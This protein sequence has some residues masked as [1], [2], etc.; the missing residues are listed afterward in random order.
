MKK[1]ILILVSSSALV[2]CNEYQHPESYSKIEYIT[3]TLNDS[4]KLVL[5]NEHYYIYQYGEYRNNMTIQHR[6]KIQ[7]STIIQDTTFIY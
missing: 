4:T 2:G 7:N 1:L 5:S 6:Q 3:R